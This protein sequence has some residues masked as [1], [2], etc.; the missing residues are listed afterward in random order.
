MRRKDREI[1]DINRMLEILR[2]CDCCRL[3]FQDGDGVYIVPLS[4]GF[5]AQDGNVCL[6]FH[7]A[8]EG[9]KI[10][11][12][13]SRPHVGFELDTGH[14]LIAGDD[15]CGYTTLYQSII[16]TG[17]ASL[18]EQAEEK[19]AALRIIMEHYSGKDDW[20]FPA[21]MIDRVAV[22]RLTVSEWS[23]KEH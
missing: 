12:V 5:L 17:E 19:A 10:D 6:Y 3:G 14:Q 7:G 15:A 16:G 13:R 1:T 21:A 8:P 9:R 4:F 20:R 2:R 22:I 23:C 18:V 11:L